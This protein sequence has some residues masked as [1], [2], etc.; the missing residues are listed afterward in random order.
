MVCIRSEMDRKMLEYAFDRFDST[1]SHNVYSCVP[2][3]YRDLVPESVPTM[4]S[5]TNSGA[6]RE[7]PTIKSIKTFLTQGPGSGGVSSFQTPSER[8]ADTW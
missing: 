6:A 8:S 1:W 7:F 5:T 2:P 3:L 4:P